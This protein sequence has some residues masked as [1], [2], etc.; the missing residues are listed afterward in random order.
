MSFYDQIRDAS[1]RTWEETITYYQ[2]EYPGSKTNKA[3]VTSYEWQSKLA[4]DVANLPAPEGKTQIK[5]ASVMRRF[6]KRAGKVASTSAKHQSEYAQV[7]ETLPIKVPSGG[8]HVTGTMKVKYSD[9]SEWDAT[10]DETITGEDAATLAGMSPEDMPQ[11]IAN[12]YQTEDVNGSGPGWLS[13]DLS[14]SPA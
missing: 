4:T 13:D 1:K 7:G 8:Y 10:I 6:Q 11:G 14:A 9:G 2:K 3:G 12:Y 5:R